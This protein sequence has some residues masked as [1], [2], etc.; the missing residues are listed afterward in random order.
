[1][2]RRS[3]GKLLPLTVFFLSFT[4]T[5][6]RAFGCSEFWSE[7]G[8][9]ASDVFIQFVQANLGENWSEKM[10]SKKY[11]SYSA[12]WEQEVVLSTRQW[13]P[14]AARN[15][16]DLLVNRVGK[17][18]TC[19]L[20]ARSLAYIKKMAP[21]NLNKKSQDALQFFQERIAFYD[22][23][24]GE[25]ETTKLMRNSLSG[26]TQGTIGQIKE[27]IQFLEGF[28]KSKD[29]VIRILIRDPHAFSLTK[30]DS[31]Q[32][33]LNFLKNLIGH[34]TLV[35]TMTRKKEDNRYGRYL[36]LSK[37]KL[38]KNILQPLI[39]NGRAIKSLKAKNSTQDTIMRLVE[40][41]Y[42]HLFQIQ[43]QVT[44]W[45]NY[46]GHFSVAQVMENSLDI[47]FDDELHTIEKKIKIAERE[48]GDNKPVI[49]FAQQDP[50]FFISSSME[51]LLDKL[52]KQQPPPLQKPKKVRA[53]GIG[54]LEGPA[55]Q[56]SFDFQ[57]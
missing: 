8:L 1:M 12:H 45:V 20:L 15:F 9:S 10:N 23:Y 43:R 28:F 35:E 29:L 6:L 51:E 38:L 19:Y 41:D 27:L 11:K 54:F 4:T 53:Y 2:L 47:L 40:L 5:G 3:Y 49:T 17:L 18:R 39:R 50:K 56:M 32:P 16:L 7:G 52:H 21:L 46:S 36:S 33:V 31:I 57:R 26:F 44:V 34:K 48:I 25:E 22:D 37:L 30:V 24:I 42:D 14:T 55:T 13:S